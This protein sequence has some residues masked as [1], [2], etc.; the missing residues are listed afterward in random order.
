MRHTNTSTT[1]RTFDAI[2]DGR[3]YIPKTQRNRLFLLREL[4]G[5][6][7]PLSEQK[8]SKLYT[9]ISGLNVEANAVIVNFIID[10]IDSDSAFFKDLYCSFLKIQKEINP[11]VFRLLFK[12]SFES[13]IR[14]CIREKKFNAMRF[15]LNHLSDYEK[16]NLLSI[17]LECGD[18]DL[19]NQALS[20]MNPKPTTEVLQYLPYMNIEEDAVVDIASDLISRNIGVAYA[21]RAASNA[22]EQKKYKLFS[23][24]MGLPTMD[25]NR[26]SC[27]LFRE[28]IYNKE[29]PCAKACILHPSMSRENAEQLLKEY[30]NHEINCDSHNSKA[31]SILRDFLDTKLSY[32]DSL[33]PSTT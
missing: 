14:F 33:V 11:E 2:E 21:M 27:F 8:I 20:I 23:L 7:N 17:S 4:L 6:E 25:V 13:Q 29:F 32:P 19:F 24:F 31:I 15:I 10:Q 16:P 28:A 12:Y 22:M 18:M 1:P 3:L 9:I 5:S 26:W 30:I